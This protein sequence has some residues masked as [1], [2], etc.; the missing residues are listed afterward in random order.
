MINP[1][2][3]FSF[4]V[5]GT[6]YVDA[7]LSS[8]HDALFIPANITHQLCMCI[9]NSSMDVYSLIF[10]QGKKHCHEVDNHILSLDPILTV[11][12]Y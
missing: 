3:V 8:I 5:D 2:Q 7:N 10:F 11:Y 1:F 6:D 9:L 4:V 12:L